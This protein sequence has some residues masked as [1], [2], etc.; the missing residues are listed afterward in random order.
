MWK[1]TNK[2]LT[3]LWLDLWSFESW[4]KL[5]YFSR[6]SE[7]RP[8]SWQIKQPREIRG[9]I[10]SN[11]IWVLNKRR[12]GAPRACGALTSSGLASVAAQPVSV[13]MFEA[14]ELPSWRFIDA[15]SHR[16]CLPAINHG[17]KGA[18][19]GK[20]LRKRAQ[21]PQ[22]S[23]QAWNLAKSVQHMFSRV[24]ITTQQKDSPA[25]HRTHTAVLQTKTWISSQSKVT[26]AQFTS[27]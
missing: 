11:K 19:S 21:A 3:V 15:R 24:R 25:R 13:F 18:C 9:Q 5:K 14:G 7:T 26:R 16:L 10:S 1:P 8:G 27:S 22:S 12:R 20:G 2:T 6:P 23:S 17:G 4:H